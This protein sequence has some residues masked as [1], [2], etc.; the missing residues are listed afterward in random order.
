MTVTTRYWS[1]TQRSN[2]QAARDAGV[3]LAF[4]SGNEV[5]WKTRLAP[6]ID[7]SNAPNTTLVTYKETHAGAVTDPSGLWTGTWRDPT[8][9]PPLDGGR[10]ENALT[11]TEFQVDAYRADS[12]T[13]PYGDTLLRFWRNTSVAQTQPGQTASLVQNILGYEWDGSPDNG[14][15]PAGLIDLSSTTL[16]V[17]ALLLDYGND[18]GA[19]SATHNLTMYRAPSGA[20]VFGAGTVFWSW[21][22]NANH[23]LTATPTDPNVQQAMVNL[24][25]DMGVQPQTLQATLQLAT[26]STDNTRP[27]STITTASG[28]SFPEGKN[29]TITGS[30]ADI[31]GLV[32]GIEVSTD[33]GTTWHPAGGSAANWTY[34]WTTPSPGT[35][36]IKSRATDD[37]VNTEIPGAGITVTVTATPTVDLFQSSDT[38]ATVTE[39]DS[40][41]V[42]LGVKFQAS[43]AGTITGFRFYKGP[44]NTGTHV[45]HLWSATGTLLASA[46]FTGETASGWQQVNLAAPVAIAPGTTY[47]ASYHTNTGFYSDT[48]NY[49]VTGHT[50]GVL[51]G[52]ASN[53]QNGPNG[54]FAYGSTSS[55][56][57]GGIEAATNYYVDVVFSPS[58]GANHVPVANNDGGFVATEN[59]PL[60]IPASALLAND[61]D[62]DGDALSITGVSNPSNGTVAYNA[63]N[64]TVQFTPTTGYTGP[65]GFTYTLTDG[66]GG[67]ASA[68]VSLTVSPTGTTASLFSASSTPGTVTR[69]DPSAVELGVK[70]QASGGGT[71]TGLR[72][73]KGPQNTGTHVGDLWSA[74]GTLLA[75]ATFTGETASGWQ[76]VN[77]ATPVTITAGTTYVAAYHTNTGFYSVDTNYFSSPLTNGPLTRAVELKQR[78]QRR[79]CLRRHGQLPPKHLQRQQ[80]LRRCRIQ[81]EHRQPCAGGQQRQR[82]RRDREHPAVD[83]GFDAA[84]QRRRP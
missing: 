35:Y 63:T 8:F 73:Y 39:N 60:S 50:S 59:T 12:I 62:P 48:S 44:Q 1:G 77:L 45:G 54:L 57:T 40:K 28:S 14:F 38:P 5:Y 81:P 46:T 2:V 27:T 47:I 21:G 16:P 78:R 9:S 79:L 49:F 65:A 30:A 52:L 61:A 80:L 6:S 67:N 68:N 55:F 58:T 72:F 71:I 51:T 82:L 33:G 75:S 70:F 18:E 13:I 76:Q 17:N 24:F 41:A 84:R 15:R 4:M 7:G 3:N 42:E 74:T 19:G 56:P 37:S 53:A 23:D 69:N 34:T 64:Q 66:R 26:R 31:G 83:P 22:L 25:A 11:G 32:A 29:V 10:P 20:L 36:T 43:V